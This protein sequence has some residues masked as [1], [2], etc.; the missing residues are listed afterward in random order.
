MYK[1]KS[2][3]LVASFI[4]L[5]MLS[6]FTAKAFSA[7]PDFV[8]EYQN[9]ANFLD[10]INAKT[11]YDQGY[12]GKG[13]DLGVFDISVRP[14][15][16]EFE[17]KIEVTPPYLTNGQAYF[18]NWEKSD[19]GTHVAGIVAA[20]RDG[21]G[22]HGV[23][24]DARL[25][26]T[27]VF[28]SAVDI[29]FDFEAFFA[30]NPEV[31]VINNSWGSPTY[32][33]FSRNITAIDGTPFVTQSDVPNIIDFL[34]DYQISSFGV[35]D[36]ALFA[37]NNPD[38]LFV[39]AAG[40]DGV[41]TGSVEDILPRY[42]G[43]ELSNWL[44]IIAVDSTQIQK[45]SNGELLVSSG[46]PAFYTNL[47]E[48]A[49]RW[50]L[51]APGSVIYSANSADNGYIKHNGTSMA[52]PVVT[53]ALGLIQEKFPWMTGKQLADTALSTANDNLTLHDYTIQFTESRSLQEYYLTFSY[54]EQAVPVLT[55]T[56][57][58][59]MLVEHFD[60]NPETWA[61]HGVDEVTYLTDFIDDGK[62]AIVGDVS[63]ES[64]FGQG[65][66]DVGKAMGGIG[67]LDANRMTEENVMSIT[68]LGNTQY[69]L[70][71]LNTQ[72]YNAEFSNDISQFQWDD[73]YHHDE[74]KSTSASG[75]NDAAL[76]LNG[77]DIGIIKSGLGRLILSG[78]NAYRGPS[79]VEGGELTIALR[80]DGSGG[81]LQF[82][83]VVVRSAG[84]L[85]GNG[86]ISTS[87]TNN[88]LV[89][90]GLFGLADPSI[91]ATTQLNVGSYTQSP[92]AT[93]QIYFDNAGNH[94]KL[95]SSAASNLDGKIL[96]S[97][98]KGFYTEKSQ[99]LIVISGAT[100]SGDFD[101]LVLDETDLHASPSL[102]F[103]I[104]AK[105]ASEYNLTISRDDE[106]YSQ[107]AL[108]DSAR[109]VGRAI[110]NLANGAS[111]DMQEL[112]TILDF[113]S[114]DGSDVGTA[115][116]QLSPES[117]E[118][119]SKAGLNQQ[120]SFNNFVMQRMLAFS[121]TSTD[122]NLSA[123]DPT[124]NGG[125]TLWGQAFGSFAHQG[126]DN[127]ISGYSSNSVGFVTGID[128]SWGN[129]LT[130]G[131]HAAIARRETEAKSPLISETDTISASFGLQ[132]HFAPQSWD[133][134]YAMAQARLG[135]EENDMERTV[136]FSTYTRS[137]QSDWTDFVGS[138][139]LG[140]GKNWQYNNFNFGPLVWLEY[141]FIERPSITEENGLASRL[142][143]DSYNHD[144][145]RTGLGFRFGYANKLSET[146]ALELDL[147]ASWKHELFDDN[148]E[149][150]GSFADYNSSRFTSE[151]P[152]IGQNVFNAH[153]SAKFIYNEN[154]YTQFNIGGEVTDEKGQALYLGLELGYEF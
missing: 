105:N 98:L 95:N 69:A 67:E 14:D 63:R 135:F 117:Y 151:S 119:L 130:T 42:M 126:N 61:L 107:Y 66:L 83:P 102:D 115:L 21:F 31:R 57:L 71:N 54:I 16:P 29:D 23:A 3:F 37:I 65:I 38:K 6:L 40:N 78:D 132:A 56:Q 114:P 70:E 110:S 17:D 80:S 99:D 18:P 82:S 111:G 47:A 11:A 4:Y 138:A 28:E 127:N 81:Q 123:G 48:G 7:S 73:K 15:H 104:Q 144:S 116:K 5:L 139:L 59:E 93:L 72:G 68:E 50:S 75:I 77:K 142:T 44:N 124:Q 85:S 129:G 106:A 35:Y 140:G 147:L 136:S 2:R 62:Y 33:Y 146:T 92:E 52:A 145:L 128:Y 125:Y 25:F 103:T 22:M 113:S 36:M 8:A 60:A 12:T 152:L 13:I 64:I 133:G 153:A 91:A 149:T 97:P 118:A 96:F 100:P 58:K 150:S 89:A 34:D 76:A 26:T 101:S 24:Y 30:Q 10:I 112:L 74:Y 87:L 148:L 137:N 86:T 49:E 9:S 122:T 84:T 19:H 51:S 27:T 143:M 46:G 108:T 154:I 1:V 121:N 131:L 43:T 32:P 109:A 79:I 141:S 94:G 55:D 88:G 90:P 53:G 134:F 20:N 120:S 41:P 39:W 45:G